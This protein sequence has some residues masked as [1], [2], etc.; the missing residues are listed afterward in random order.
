M[1]AFNGYLSNTTELISS[2]TTSKTVYETKLGGLIRR[3][4]QAPAAW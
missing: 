2:F 1:I 4:V 3:E